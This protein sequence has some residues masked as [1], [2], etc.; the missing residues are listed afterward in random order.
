MLPLTWA[1]LSNSSSLKNPGLPAAPQE[2]PDPFSVLATIA[3]FRGESLPKTSYDQQ[4][5]DTEQSRKILELRRL[6][7]AFYEG[8]SQVTGLQIPLRQ[9]ERAAGQ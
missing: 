7:C 6:V 4:R 1:A 2:F 3:V 5:W 9:E 8:D